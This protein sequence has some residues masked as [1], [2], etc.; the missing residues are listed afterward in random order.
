MILTA[1]LFG[2]ASGAMTFQNGTPLDLKLVKGIDKKYGYMPSIRQFTKDM[3]AGMTKV[4]PM[5]NPWYGVLEFGPSDHLVK[6]FIAED[7]PAGKKHTLYVDANGNGDLT[8]DPAFE[9][10]LTIDAPQF[11]P[12]EKVQVGMYLTQA[13]PFGPDKCDPLW[14]FANYFWEGKTR[15]G[16]ATYPIRVW[17]SKARMDFSRNFTDEIA[18]DTPMMLDVNQDGLIAGTESTDGRKPFNVGGKSYQLTG[19]SA[20]PTSL[21]V[22]PSSTVV[23]AMPVFPKVVPHAVGDAF[24]PVSDKTVDGRKLDLRRDFKGKVVLVDFWATWCGPCLAESPNVVKTY[25]DLRSKGFEVVGISLDD[26]TTKDKIPAVTKEKSMTWPQICDGGGWKTPYAQRLD[27]E[28][29]PSAFLIDGDTGKI[30]ATTND[31]RGEKL[32]ETV[33][34]ALADKKSH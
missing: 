10:Y 19:W 31:L 22:V 2:V 30:L 11:G 9:K 28:S 21:R 6:V 3:P 29:I 13:L 12:G 16:N 34:K 26:N 23:A 5:E 7:A 14:I 18:S 32:A 25:A 27:I 1:L 4:P 20:S 8:D 17:D 33:T 15:L 24:P